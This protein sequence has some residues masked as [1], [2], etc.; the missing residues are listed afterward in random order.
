MDQTPPHKP[1]SPQ[2]IFSVPGQNGSPTEPYLG[3]SVLDFDST[4]YSWNGYEE[5][6]LENIISASL[7]QETLRKNFEVLMSGMKNHGTSL[8]KLA[9]QNGAIDENIMEM[10]HLVS[11][12]EGRIGEA[13]EQNKEI[14][15]EIEN[16]KIL[17]KSSGCS[18]QEELLAIKDKL[19][20]LDYLKDHLKLGDDKNKELEQKNK[21]LI[22]VWQKN[23][24]KV[25]EHDVNFKFF[26]K[27][28]NF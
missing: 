21:E 16:L 10:K 9:K 15:L 2:Q 26:K 8:L 22:G 12:N 11:R 17:Q 27:L 5:I 13:F 18:C 23:E 7:N 3:R 1:T 25:K 6:V 14:L 19:K 24:E 28:K 20:E 4:N